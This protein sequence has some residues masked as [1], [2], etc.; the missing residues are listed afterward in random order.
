MNCQHCKS[1]LTSKRAKQCP[2]CAT[3]KNDAH[4]CGTYA[5]TM[6]GF[7][8][9]KA[10]GLTGQAMRDFVLGKTAA[11]VAENHREA[12]KRRANREAAI[13][14]VGVR[15]CCDTRHGSEHQFWCEFSPA[16]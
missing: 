2:A 16:G 14:R 5:A 9:A 13:A 1:E 11:A 12:D 4:R 3:I 7:S 10:H 8:K 6:E 15:R